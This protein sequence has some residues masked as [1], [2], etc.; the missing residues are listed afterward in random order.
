M[1]CTYFYRLSY[2]SMMLSLTSRQAESRGRITASHCTFP[3]G[4]R[5][6]RASPR[7]AKGGRKAAVQ[8]ELPPYSPDSSN[9]T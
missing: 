6:I 3:Q 4:Q 7:V 9:N 2:V 1:F 8:F 5:T